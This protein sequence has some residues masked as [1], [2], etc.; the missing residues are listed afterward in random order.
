MMM[1]DI[2]LITNSPEFWLAL[3]FLL[4]VYFSYRLIRNSIAAIID[5]YI[6]NVTKYIVE[7]E[8]LLTESKIS[9]LTIENKL[10]DLQS[11]E[12]NVLKQTNDLLDQL[13]K[14]KEKELAHLVST[15]E[16]L[17]SNSIES[18]IH[19]YN[20]NILDEIYV[21]VKTEVIEKFSN[22]NNHTP[23]LSDLEI[24]KCFSA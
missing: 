3:G 16:R 14:D 21:K 1:K 24:K 10:A 8:N 5:D 13:K 15:E 6:G 17:S 20:Q 19:K 18:L 9:L 7:A 2:D 4:F 11:Y 12:E 23:M 22:K